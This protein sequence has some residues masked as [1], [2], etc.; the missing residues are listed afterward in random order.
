M[1]IVWINDLYRKGWGGENRPIFSRQVAKK[2][3]FLLLPF[4]IPIEGQ[5]KGGEEIRLFFDFLIENS[6]LF[7]ACTSLGEYITL[8]QKFVKKNPGLRSRG[9][10]VRGSLDFEN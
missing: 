3:L 8:F 1:L 6:W 10:G 5:R 4:S 7:L 2:L 9:P